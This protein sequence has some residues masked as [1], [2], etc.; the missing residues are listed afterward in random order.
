MGLQ[1]FRV[2][3]RVQAPVERVWELVD[4]S[5]SWP[6]WTPIDDVEIVVP[7]PEQAPGEVRIVR[8]GRYTLRERIIERVR[9]HRLVYTVESGLAVR[10][11]RAAISLAAEEDGGATQVD[12][13][14]TFA[15]KVPGFGGVYRRA[16]E[17]ATRQF[18]AGLTQASVAPADASRAEARA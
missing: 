6:R 1:E 7:A 14:T 11:Y 13:H 15:A 17:K 18:V 2:S 4:D 5:R 16:L 12:W 8:N 10:D 9:P 3:A